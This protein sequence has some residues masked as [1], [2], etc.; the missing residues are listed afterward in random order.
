M[1]MAVSVRT[2][3]LAMWVRRL[4][5]LAITPQPVHDR[6]GSSPMISMRPLRPGKRGGESSQLFHH[7]V[8]DLLIAP[9]GLHVVVVVEHVDQ[10]EQGGGVGLAHVGLEAGL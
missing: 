1:G 2:C 3:P 7:R 9:Y 10:L 6:P 5:T 8:A 4:P